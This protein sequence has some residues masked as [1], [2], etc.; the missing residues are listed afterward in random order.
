[1]AKT[2]DIDV[3]L[4]AHDPRPDI[5]AITIASIARQTLSKERYR[6]TLIDNASIVPIEPSVFA[7]LESV[8]V[9][10]RLVREPILGNAYA[11][12]RAFREASAQYIAFIDDDNEL[13]RDY[14]AQ[15]LEIMSNDQS[16]GCLG[17]KLVRAP[18]LKVP[19]WLEPLRSYMAI[20]D[21]L[22]DVA[23]IGSILNGGL[24][25]PP[26]AGMILRSELGELY[27]RMERFFPLLGRRGRRG[28]R[29]MEDNLI[30]RQAASLGFVCAYD[31]RLRLVHHIDQARLRFGYV[32]RLLYGQGASETALS[33]ILGRKLEG[34]QHRLRAL[35]NDVIGMAARQPDPRTLACVAIRHLGMAVER[36]FGQRVSGIPRT[37]RRGV[38]F[39]A[40]DAVFDQAVAFLN[41]FRQSNPDLDLCLI[42]FRSDIERLRRLGPIFKFSIFDEWELF[43]LTDIVSSKLH[44]NPVGEYR[45]LAAWHGP[46]ER[47]IYVDVDTIVLSNFDFA[48]D[49][50]DR[51]DFIVSH[52]NMDEI[53]KFV[54]KD[55][56]VRSGL[57]SKSQIAYSA[58]TGFI[59]SSK[60]LL[61][62]R[63][64][65]GHIDRIARFAPYMELSSREQPL[66]NYLI[67]T[68]GMRRTSLHVLRWQKRMPGIPQEA[69]AGAEASVL[70]PDGMT[71]LDGKE[72]RPLLIH[73]AGFWSA[74]RL[75]YGWNGRKEFPLKELWLR[76]RNLNKE[77]EK[78]DGSRL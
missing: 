36:I 51:Y 27:L 77:I 17:G 13:D 69:W 30:T 39:L 32:T 14:L 5:L 49:L 52:S 22:G 73:W 61:S 9:E 57:L 72:E 55:S 31:P 19:T 18:Y 46:F 23:I 37:L 43:R 6:F 44:G 48:F 7:S 45:K 24:A 38:Y 75:G 21:Y 65:V 15:G 40:N 29:S 4:C 47:F 71:V 67:V 8:G 59:V 60:G 64:I 53:R 25:E 33:R 11:R 42:P 78:F 50:L 26:S 74:W 68:G 41:S 2:P 34:W 76:Y 35:L 16:I 3:F 66:L 20:R 28:L 56:I 62:I 70:R 63:K 58:N 54:W 12:A 1:M 10:C